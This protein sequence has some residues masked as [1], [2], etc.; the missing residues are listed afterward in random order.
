MSTQAEGASAPKVTL[1]D[2]KAV[3]T[4]IAVAEYFHKQHKH[5]LDAIEKLKAEC[6][7]EFN[8]PNFRLVEY[9][10]AK[11]EKR[12]AYE[13]TRDGFT[14]LV[15]GFTGQKALQWKLKYLEAFNRLEAKLM[16]REKL[17]A[18][19]AMRQ[20]PDPSSPALPAPATR[21]LP[22]EVIRAMNRL[23]HGLSMKGFD[24]IRSRIE[25]R[26]KEMWPGRSPEELLHWLKDCGGPDAE[27]IVLSAH[28]LWSLTSRIKACSI[29]IEGAIEQVH[30]LEEKTG[31]I[32][33]GRGS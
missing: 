27:L 4:S 29:G 17:R 3:T 20:A 26:L 10:D 30:A 7:P 14:L 22:A 9:T 23:A 32:W 6:P 13:L 25:E 2:G 12:P 8:E 5:V 18:E 24:D 33:Y 19:R 31:R 15:M 1:H 21:E 11:G 28:E 16:K